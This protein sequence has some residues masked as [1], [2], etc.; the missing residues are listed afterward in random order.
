MSAQ[1]PTVIYITPTEA[2]LEASEG[3]VDRLDRS[4]SLTIPDAHHTDYCLYPWERVSFRAVSRDGT[5]YEKDSDFVFKDPINPSID[6][7]FPG[8][9][10]REHYA[11]LYVANGPD[12]VTFTLLSRYVPD[13]DRR[14]WTVEHFNATQDHTLERR[15]DRLCSCAEPD[16][17]LQS[18]PTEL[19]D[20]LI[21]AINTEYS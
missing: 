13:R 5:V 9:G 7:D 12:D 8:S 17:V 16:C 18:V 11:K 14:T 20:T 19:A 10:V 15:D 1:H 4:A 21:E 6:T 3:A 2:P